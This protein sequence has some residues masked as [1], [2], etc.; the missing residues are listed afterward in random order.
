MMLFLPQYFN[1]P[2]HENKKIHNFRKII[3]YVTLHVNY[4]RK[5]T[6]KLT[7]E[8]LKNTNRQFLFIINLFIV[9]NI[10]F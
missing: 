5:S 2:G 10:L 1:L 6:K 4:D 7:L 3:C 8:V 9:T